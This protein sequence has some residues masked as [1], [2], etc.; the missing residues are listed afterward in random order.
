M[1][2]LKKLTFVFTVLF[3]DFTYAEPITL[4]KKNIHLQ[5]TAQTEQEPYQSSF[6]IFRTNKT[7]LRTFITVPFL[8]EERV[9]FQGHTKVWYVGQTQ[10]SKFVCDEYIWETFRKVKKFVLHFRH[11]KVLKEGEIERYRLYF[12]QEEF[13]SRYLTIEGVSLSH[14]KEYKISKASLWRFHRGLVFEHFATD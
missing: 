9:C 3:T 13:R 7:R 1:T 6:E 10:H 4:D 12:N 2:V 11:A 8:Y 14:P 5:N